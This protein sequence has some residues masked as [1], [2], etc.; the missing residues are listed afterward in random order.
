MITLIVKVN[1]EPDNY[2]DLIYETK[3]AQKQTLLEP[4]CKGYTIN[5]DLENPSGIVLIESYDSEMAIEYH[6][7]TP[8]FLKWRENVQ[9]YMASPR[10]S[11]KYTSI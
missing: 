5:R 2:G 6:K 1:V 7:T 8:H 4:G 11:V 10:T 9:P 3:I